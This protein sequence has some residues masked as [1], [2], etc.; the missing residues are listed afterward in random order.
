M[1]L[2]R[3]AW[4]ECSCFWKST[5]FSEADGGKNKCRWLAGCGMLALPL[6]ASETQEAVIGLRLWFVSRPICH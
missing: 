3:A 6:L 2:S 1:E 4:R 5:V